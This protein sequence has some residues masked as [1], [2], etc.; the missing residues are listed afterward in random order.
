[1]TTWS[2]SLAAPT[3]TGSSTERL[4]Y[5]DVSMAA[6]VYDH[7]ISSVDRRLGML[8]EELSRRGVLD[9]AL[10]EMIKV[11]PAVRLRGLAP[12]AC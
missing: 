1:M 6:D 2:G 10:G 9:N 7:C 11:D 8:V 4:S 3:A 5:D 12:F